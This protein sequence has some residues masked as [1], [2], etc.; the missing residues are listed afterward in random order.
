MGERAP[1][2][3]CVPGPVVRFGHMDCLVSHNCYYFLVWLM[4]PNKTN[5]FVIIG[6][7][8]ED[9]AKR[10]VS[11]RL[12]KFIWI[13]L[14]FIQFE[15]CYFGWRAMRDVIVIHSSVRSNRLWELQ[16]S[17]TTLPSIRQNHPQS[18]RYADSPIHFR[19]HQRNCQTWL[20]VIA[21]NKTTQ[22]MHNR[23]CQF[24]NKTTNQRINQPTM[25]KATNE[26]FNQI[27]NLNLFVII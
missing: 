22:E 15:T 20:L 8:L 9:D 13:L 10:D 11:C 23:T 26:K 2:V 4:F 24:V 1:I 5:H 12:V 21:A 3:R 14:A 18:S 27:F 6:L 7:A 17:P 16:L 19:G 25:P